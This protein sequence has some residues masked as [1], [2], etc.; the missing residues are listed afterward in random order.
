MLRYKFLIIWLVMSCAA[1]AQQLTTNWTF[2]AGARV[3]GEAAL[4]HDNLYFG[5]VKGTFYSLNTNTGKIN[6]TFETGVPIQSRPLIEGNHIY[7]EA[8]VDLYKITNSGKLIWHYASGDVPEKFSYDDKDYL[9]T[10]DS[11]D[12]KH[13]NPVIYNNYLII[14]MASGRLVFLDKETGTPVKTIYSITGAPI[15]ST[16]TVNDDMLYFGDWEGYVYAFDIKGWQLRWIKK[17]YDNATK[18]YPTFG[19]IASDFTVYEEHLY[20]GLRNPQLQVLDVNTG[21]IKWTYSD[22]DGGWMIGDPRVYNDT[23]YIAGSDNYAMFAF[24]PTSGRTFWKHQRKL[25]IYSRPLIT[26]EHIIYTSADSYAP[27]KDGEIVILDRI[28]GKLVTSYG[29]AYGAFA[30][31]LMDQQSNILFIS[32]RGVV[33]SMRFLAK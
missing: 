32:N 20:F 13:S 1:A 17:T 2:E 4:H 33:H 6:W 24:H 31:P 26:P 18:P 10:L 9:Y 22:S 7:F 15:R 29:F 14:G 8:G 19:G 25:N 23:L 3:I 21:N 12:D 16:P 27:Q 5:N 30:P 11:W 28:T